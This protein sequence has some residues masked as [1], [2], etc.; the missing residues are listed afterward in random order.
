MAMLASCGYLVGTC[1]SSL[2]RL[3]SELALAG[4]G[5][6]APPIALDYESCAAFS[7]HYYPIE[8]PWTKE[9]GAEEGEREGQ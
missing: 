3:A 6:R 4:G 8:M 7:T 2:S 1:M 5:L 9:W